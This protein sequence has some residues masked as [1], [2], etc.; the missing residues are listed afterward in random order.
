MVAVGESAAAAASVFVAPATYVGVRASVAAAASTAWVTGRTA[1]EVG[2]SVADADSVIEATPAIVADFVSVA[3]AASTAC[4]TGRVAPADGLS[5]AVAGSVLVAPA[6]R[7]TV[8]T[9]AAERVRHGASPD[10]VRLVAAR[11][12]ELAAAVHAVG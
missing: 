11:A 5:A 6:A 4:V 3:L 10:L 12:G 8:W 2:A 9:D 1:P 7:T